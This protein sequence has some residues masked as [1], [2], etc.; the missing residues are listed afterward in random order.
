QLYNLTLREQEI[1]KLICEGNKYKDIGETLFIAERTVTK[2]VQNIF[3]KVQVS[4]KIE[5]NNK[6]GC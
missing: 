2:H 5:L 3:E 6:L 4:N 1:A